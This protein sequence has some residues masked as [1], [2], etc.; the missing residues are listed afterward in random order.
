MKKLIFLIVGLWVFTLNGQT[1]NNLTPSL[2]DQ[3]SGPEVRDINLTTDLAALLASQNAE[4]EYQKATISYDMNGG[5]SISWELKVRVRGKFRRQTCDFPPLKLNFSKDDLT[6]RGLASFDKFKLVTHCLEDPGMGE[7]LVL[8]EYLAY[9]LYQSLSPYSYRVQLVRIHYEDSERAVSGFSRY[10]F[11]IES[12]DEMAARLGSIECDACMYASSALIDEELA[13][14][15]ALFQYLIGNSD[16]S[17]PVQRNV[18][19]IRRF[20]DGKLI[21]VGYDFDFSGL[22][23]APYAIPSNNLGQLTNR[24]RIFLGRIA[25]DDEMGQTVQLFLDRREEILRTIEEFDLLSNEGR[26]DLREYVLTF[27]DQMSILLASG[28]QDFYFRLREEHPNAVPDGGN[29]VNYG[30]PANNR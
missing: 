21:P 12:T 1:L 22:V 26:A 29:P 2:F 24:Q 7:A 23:N 28:T 18:K 27:Y 20:A 6:A 8:K 19:L 16:Y 25:H 10:G 4:A 30:L 17:L 5:E 15:H 9:Q 11:L 3:I 13:R 14:T